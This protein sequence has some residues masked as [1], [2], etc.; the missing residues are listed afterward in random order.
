MYK[1]KVY[2]RGSSFDIGILR[3]IYYSLYGEDYDVKMPFRY[4]RERD[5]R[6]FIE[7]MMSIRGDVDAYK[8]PVPS[9]LLAG[10]VKH[11]SIHDCAKDIIAMHMS[12]LYAMCDDHPLFHEQSY[13]EC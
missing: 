8:V 11:N 7:D 5:V 9:R 3:S 12:R 2:A 4:W 6:T 1:M 13:I 10:F